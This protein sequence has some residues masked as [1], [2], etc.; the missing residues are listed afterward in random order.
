[1][2]SS[3][4][5]PKE[6][7]NGS[8]QIGSTEAPVECILI[9][10]GVP[11]LYLFWRFNRI[12]GWAALGFCAA[13]FAWGY[14][15]GASRSLDFLQPGRHTYAF[16]IALAIAGGALLHELFKR[17]R[18]HR[19]G[20]PR[21]DLWAMAG[22]MLIGIRLI[23]SRRL[24]RCGRAAGILFAPSHFSRA[25]RPHELYGSSIASVAI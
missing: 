11:G 6:C 20:M 8:R 13:G 17:L 16:F 9:A 2:I 14:L 25:A 5:T 1:M 19:R 24:S 3:F 15:A 10:A 18:S 21:L 4:A 12:L 23:G 7:C 22:A